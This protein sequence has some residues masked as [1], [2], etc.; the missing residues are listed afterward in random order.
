MFNHMAKTAVA[1]NVALYAHIQTHQCGNLPSELEIHYGFLSSTL[2][3]IE[4][5]SYSEPSW[6]VQFY[7]KS[8]QFL[9]WYSL[10][11]SLQVNSRRYK[12]HFV[13]FTKLFL[14]KTIRL[15]SS[16]SH[17]GNKGKSISCVTAYC[18]VPSSP[19]AIHYSTTVKES[20]ISVSY[21]RVPI[22]PNRLAS[23]D[24]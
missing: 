3:C 13:P 16:D 23:D 17:A 6:I 10:K 18:F 9:K 14:Q 7:W 24:H 19:N 4:S 11:R 21:I 8:R 22:S 12:S 20:E 5:C 2:S 1:I 15:H